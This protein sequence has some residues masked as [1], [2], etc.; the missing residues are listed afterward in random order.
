MNSSV[1]EIQEGEF[2]LE[3]FRKKLNDQVY[4]ILR[5]SNSFHFNILK[6]R[7]QKISEKKAGV[8]LG[9]E[10]SDHELDNL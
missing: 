1:I 10:I 9:R 6:T 5:I 2:I 8:L 4:D 7:I 3:S